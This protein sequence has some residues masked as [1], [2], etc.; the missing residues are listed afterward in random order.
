M[1]ILSRFCR[2]WAVC[3]LAFLVVLSSSGIFLIPA[4]AA[5][6][7]LS[8]YY[9]GF[10]WKNNYTFTNPVNGQTETFRAG[11][12]LPR[13]WFKSA[14]IP[15]Y[16]IEPGAPI[17]KGSTFGSG[18]TN[19][20]KKIG[21]VKQWW[22]SWV[23][24]YGYPNNTAFTG[25][26][27]IGYPITQIIIWEYI[28]GYRDLDTSVCHNRALI[29]NL[30]VP[31]GYRSTYMSYYNDLDQMLV[32]NSVAPSFM[33]KVLSKAPTYTLKYNAAAGDYEITLTDSNSVA[34]LPDMNLSANGITFRKLNSRTLKVS[35]KKIISKSSPVSIKATKNIPVV[36][37]SEGVAVWSSANKQQLVT[38]AQRPDPVP[39]YMK[40]Q[41]E[42]VGSMK[43][44]KQS[45][46]GIVANRTFRISGNGIS[47]TVKTGADGT[48]TVPNLNAGAYTV[49]EISTPVQYNQPKA[50]TVTVLPERTVT[51]SFS[52]TLKK[53][54]VKFVK[55]DSYSGGY[56]SGAKYRIYKSN[57]AFVC[58]LTANASKW[59]YSPYLPYG[60]YYIKES[61]AAEFFA[62]DTKKYNFSIRTNEQAIPMTLKDLP[63]SDVY[64]TFIKPNAT[65]RAG[66][67]IIASYFIHNNSVAEHAPDRP[68]TVHFT[69]YTMKNG[70]RQNITTQTNK[71]IVPRGNV[72]LTYF[73][74]KLPAGSSNVHYSCTVDT[75][76][77]VYETN[78]ENNTDSKTAGVL[79]PQNSQTPNTE[80]ENRPF[81]FNKPDDSAG[82]PTGDYASNVTPNASWEQYE[83]VNG[84][85][86]KK[87]YGVKLTANQQI[88]P[89][90]NSLS[91]YLEN[92]LWH[93]KSG[94]GFS[95]SAVSHAARFES[96][97]LANAGSYI[98][99]QNGNAYFPEFNFE[100]TDAKYRTLQLTAAN[101]LE[102]VRNPYSITKKG[103]KD[104]RRI[105]YTPL[106][107]PDGNYTVKTFLYD[108]WTPA[109]MISLQD[110]L[111][112]IVI[113]SNIYDDWY[114][115]HG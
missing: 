22:I 109:G 16:C 70:T 25:D 15:G 47:K 57:G 83:W 40:L 19:Y 110:T 29:N 92:G 28:L 61:K 5:S 12:N 75:P 7:T 6:N 74:V 36:S 37:R 101:K 65:Y 115:N 91:H 103:V 89:D 31:S 113:G 97:I 82:I 96:T 32:R 62:L 56:L 41:T 38:G 111:S 63:L 1:S 95:L 106:W 76:S 30:S 66:T 71:V 54:R 20:W 2:K 99:P 18:D 59:V 55:Q 112:P 80:F 60:D 24:L 98:L 81:Y 67:E 64:P 44:V 8:I 43:I 77:G 46:D 90:V 78:T 52:N 21:P 85:F 87:T 34:S 107:Y 11:E 114:I 108:C 4:S 88:I 79:T 26:A 93:M 23:L 100:L 94:Y 72:N 105:H 45:E 84:A 9:D 39:G 86:Q 10:S 50:Q 35:T 14:G 33:S 48:V 51:A 58:E 17:S 68:L 53:G 73:K 49:Q 104:G 13:L 42:S 27:Y 69:A 102:F 3:L